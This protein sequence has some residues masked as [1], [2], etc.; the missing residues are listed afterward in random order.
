MPMCKS[1][2]RLHAEQC[3]V[4]RMY[5]TETR[6]ARF[7]AF[8]QLFSAAHGSIA[9]DFLHSPDGSGL[10]CPVVSN[11]AHTPRPRRECGRFMAS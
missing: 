6:T 10:N 7:P 9:G 2:A 11:T 1:L 5:S 8:T 4:L 3:G